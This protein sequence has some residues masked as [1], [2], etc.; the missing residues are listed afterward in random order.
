MAK[1]Y[2]ETMKTW[3]GKLES[4]VGDQWCVGK[5][6]SLADIVLYVALTQ[7]FSDAEK[8]AASYVDCPKV[9]AIVDKVGENAGIQKW[10]ETRPENRF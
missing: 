7:A 9:S 3:M 1:W 5:K 4:V 8:A 6:M 10:L 2:D